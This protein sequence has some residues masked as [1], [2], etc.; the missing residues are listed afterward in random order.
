MPEM[1]I[2]PA[3]TTTREAISR[4]KL[5]ALVRA[6]WGTEATEASIKANFPGGAGLRPATDGAPAYVLLEKAT[7]RSLGGVLA[8]ALRQQ[9]GAGEV[10]L[11]AELAGTS[12]ETAALLTRRAHAFARP[13][14][15][16]HVDP[17]SLKEVPPAAFDAPP[18]LPAEAKPWADVLRKAGLEV[19]V[20]FGVLTGEL[21]G[22]EVARV[23]VADNEARL[24]VGVGSQDRRARQEVQADRD[25][26]E[27]LAEVVKLIG[28]VR[29]PKNKAH[30]ASTLAPERW[31]RSVL[32]GRPDQV[33]AAWLAPVP[34]PV[35]RRDL[36]ERG[37]ALAAG[38]DGDGRPV[39][40]AAS[41][42]IDLDLVPE[43][44]D[45]RRACGLDQAALQLAM[46]PAD[47]HPR[48][49]QLAALLKD[50]AEVVTVA[51]DWKC[52][53]DWKGSAG[54]L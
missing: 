52:S 42:G 40:V 53:T 51:P 5:D 7:H 3:Q 6:H 45:G 12:E 34:P 28:A 17:P 43:A 10:H 1:T 21:L 22:L 23:V 38:V 29:T 48:T 20:E 18:E 26:E 8:W 19:V 46:V 9:A 50:P 30:L 54:T 49:R 15:V 25:P 33:G 31:L 44:A 2:E 47:D 35:T 32:V 39:V 13:V 37:A 24:E 14:K 4:A 36:R 41:V 16:W 11:L 27:Q